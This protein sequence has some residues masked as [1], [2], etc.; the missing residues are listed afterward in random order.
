MNRRLVHIISF[1][2]LFAFLISSGS[3]TA[4]NISCTYSYWKKNTTDPEAK[5][6]VVHD[7]KVDKYDKQT[8]YYCESTFIRDSIRSVAFDS[9]GMT[10]DEE[11]YAQL[12]RIQSGNKDIAICD[13]EEKTMTVG[14]EL[15]TTI[16]LGTNNLELPKWDLLEESRV[17]N[18][19]S[20]HKAVSNY[21]GRE[22]IA[23]FTD[24]I[25]I[26]TGPWLL[27]GTPGLIVEAR[28]AENI[29]VF[30]LTGTEKLPDRHKMD[31]MRLFYSE[32]HAEGQ[33][34]AFPM[35]K[36]ESLHTKAMTDHDFFFQLLGISTVYRINSSGNKEE[37][38]IPPYIPLIP[39]EY[40]S[41]HAIKP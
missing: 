33:H 13:F 21:L 3:A 37:A 30:R 39:S 31:F 34:F 8:V 32:K 5:Y 24:E 41:N 22:W 16:V 18:G 10:I 26:S 23:W 35:K 17:I 2:L 6:R 15:G 20:C 19:Y 36:A 14:Y 40:W 38:K 29:A 1:A 9:Q 28:D 12:T 7:M 27:W 11:A 4:Q 25:P